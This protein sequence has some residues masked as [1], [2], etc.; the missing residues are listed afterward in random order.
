MTK[1][2]RQETVPNRLYARCPREDGFDPEA[3]GAVL[4]EADGDERY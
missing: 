1:L 2:L 4:V 3:A